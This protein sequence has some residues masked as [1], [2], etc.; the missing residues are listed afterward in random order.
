[1]PMET[2]TYPG[3]RVK[4]CEKLEIWTWAEFKSLLCHIRVRTVLLCKRFLWAPVTISCLRDF[5][6][7]MGDLVVIRHQV[8]TTIGAQQ[9]ALPRLMPCVI[10]IPDSVQWPSQCAI[11]NHLFWTSGKTQYHRPHY[12]QQQT[13]QI[14]SVLPQPARKNTRCANSTPRPPALCWTESASNVRMRARVT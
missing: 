8:L 1:M 13:W 9:C 10:L 6:C 14:S 5:L 4:E 2:R 3:G 12:Q 11:I 7:G